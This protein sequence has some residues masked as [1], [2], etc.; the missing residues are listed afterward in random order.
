VNNDFVNPK[1]EGAPLE[2][3]LVRLETTGL[4]EDPWMGGNMQ[5]RAGAARM[6]SARWQPCCDPPPSTPT[7][8]PPTT[9]GF[10]AT[11]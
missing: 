3:P 2:S 11:G 7:V 4:Q 9:L 8:R 6:L 10:G 5:A 1:A